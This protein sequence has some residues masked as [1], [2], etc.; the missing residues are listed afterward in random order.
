[1]PQMVR[2]E[3]VPLVRTG[4][5]YPL[6]TGPK[7][8]TEE[9]LQ[10]AVA[11][12][13]NDPAVHA[14]RIKIDGLAESFDPQAHGGEPALG[15]VED[16]AVS[17]DG[18]TLTGTMVIPEWLG[19]VADFAYPN[20]SIEGIS[21]L[22]TP[23]G[24]SHDLVVTAVVLLGV[25][26]P[27]VST[28]PDLAEF[29]A[30]GPAGD[31]PTPEAIAAAASW[32]GEPLRAGM[33]QDIVRRRLIDWMMAGAGD[34]LPDEN[35]SPWDLWPVAL[36]FDDGGKPYA[37]VLD[38]GTGRLYRV[39]ITVSGND[40]SFGDFIEVVEQD[41]PVAASAGD[42]RR[43]LVWASRADQRP[44]PRQ[45]ERDEMNVA[46]LREA[47]GLTAEQLPDD[48]T[49]AQVAEALRQPVPDP[50]PSEE[51]EQEVPTPEQP[52]PVAA[53]AALPEG[54]V[55]VDAATLE[56][57]KAGAQTAQQLAKEK[58][59]GDRDRTIQA[60]IKAGK[61]TPAR[62][63]HFERLWAKDPEGTKHT[64]TADPSDGGLAA[65]LV[66]VQ[67]IGG[68]PQD[69]AGNVSEQEHEQFMAQQFPGS[70]APRKRG[71]QHRVG[72]EA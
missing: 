24:Q 72:Q 57:L 11:A 69:A 67:E 43:G 47:A 60:A 12:V 28:L 66:P 42:T 48:A 32:E 26:L 45:Q 33:D 7:T 59:D 10:A 9:D 22:H 38:E 51:E 21:G 52:E 29:L 64:L 56:E 37:K 15:W 41:V 61:F 20:R 36:R 13:A 54:V 31:A 39:D 55:A 16:L 18:Q 50:T 53:S 70:R 40:V 6:S 19:D 25:D 14:P 30:N 68:E 4:I 27:G 5:D 44:T 23:T 65:N 3:N 71:I 63:E 49:P 62:R 8:F 2:I 46:E 34:N 17:G 58:A 1:M 35:D